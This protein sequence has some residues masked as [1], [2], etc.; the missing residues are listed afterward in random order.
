MG[1]FR[2]GSTKCGRLAEGLIPKYAAMFEAKSPANTRVK[3]FRK[4]NRKDE[5][6][7][8]IRRAYT[9]DSVPP[10]EMSDDGLFV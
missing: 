9:G 4:K 8:D 5:S 10:I 1:K 6:S 3:Q 7:N 2:I